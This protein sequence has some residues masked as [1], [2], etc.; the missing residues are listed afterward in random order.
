MGELTG[1]KVLMIAVASF[2]IVIA[3]NVVMAWQAVAT[4][5]GIETASSYQAS[6]EFDVH[7]SAQL[8]L[9]WTVDARYADKV[10]EIEITGPDGGPAEISSMAA[11]VGWATSTRDDVTPEFTR[12]GAVYATPLDLPDGNWNIRLKAVAADGTEFSRRIP[13]PIRNGQG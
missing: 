10:L 6:Q 12:N 3:V 13:F 11:L 4:F 1:F 5:P 2:G 8:A 7:K 9:G